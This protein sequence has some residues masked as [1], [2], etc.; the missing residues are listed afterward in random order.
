MNGSCKR[1]GWWTGSPGGTRLPDSNLLSR[2]R[3]PRLFSTILGFPK[4]LGE[5]LA[6]GWKEHYWDTL[7]KYLA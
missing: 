5:H 2:V 7:E 6:S 1:G 3:A 4:G